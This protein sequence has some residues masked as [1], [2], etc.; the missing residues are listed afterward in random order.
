MIILTELVRNIIVLL[1]L[2]TFLEMILPSSNMQRFL[3]V[4]LGLFM[5]V[6]LL[7]PFLNLV[8][9]YHQ[10]NFAVQK[11]NQDLFRENYR[12][13]MEKQIEHLF[14]VANSEQPVAIEVKLDQIG[15]KGSREIIRE[16]VVTVEQ[17]KQEGEKM[18]EVVVQ[19]E[20]II[21]M[22]CRYFGLKEKQILVKLR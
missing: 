16:I 1:L 21:Y 4:V 20:E 7:N 3:K 22:L 8:N 10:Q 14:K 5:L 19:E 9:K 17:K 6:T 18:S 12:Q 2:T 11:T 15:A 13:S